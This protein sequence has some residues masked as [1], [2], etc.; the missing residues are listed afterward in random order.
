MSGWFYQTEDGAKNGPISN[1]QIAELAE[2]GKLALH[3]QV[4]HDEKTRGVWVT[5]SRIVGLKNRINAVWQAV[6][7]EREVV[8]AAEEADV[9]GYGWQSETPSE[10]TDESGYELQ[11]ETP[12]EEVACHAAP[13]DR[14]Q[15]QFSLK[16]PRPPDRGQQH[17]TEGYVMEIAFAP[18]DDLIFTGLYPENRGIFLWSLSNGEPRGELIRAHDCGLKDIVVDPVRH[19]AAC[20]VDQRP[21]VCFFDV[22]TQQLIKDIELC[23]T[24]THCFHH[25]GYYVAA[26]NLLHGIFFFPLDT[27][28]PRLLSK[29]SPSRI[30]E[31]IAIS[32]DGDLLAY[33]TYEGTAHVHSISN[34]EQVLE[35]NR[36]PRSI[37]RDAEFR[38]DS[39]AISNNNELFAHSIARHGVEI[40]PVTGED[41]RVSC[42]DSKM[43]FY[44]LLF[45]PD[46][47]R[48]VGVGYRNT[49]IWDVANGE[50][51]DSWDKGGKAIFEKDGSLIIAL[52]PTIDRVPNPTVH[53]LR[54]S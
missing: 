25:D 21:R 24:F 51:V 41:T 33:G 22:L 30:V 35:I 54:W 26:S 4:F 47:N 49:R 29:I 52:R 31:S 38:I 28:E 11:P 16:V 23:F 32:T 7:S 36:D 39:V 14:W 48:L 6:E 44:Q 37:G 43:H 2:T 1:G 27:F 17:G 50:L 20:K 5:A 13:R 42:E 15:P 18:A 19:L 10:V 53:V 45:S 12:A 8:E 34:G 46:D 40:G 3:T 9:S